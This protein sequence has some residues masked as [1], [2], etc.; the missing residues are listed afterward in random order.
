MSQYL[1]SL[2]LEDTIDVRGPAGHLTYLG[3]G[4]IIATVKFCLNIHIANSCLNIIENC[5]LKE[6]VTHACIPY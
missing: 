1:N 5:P 4:N 3:R 2:N 6:F